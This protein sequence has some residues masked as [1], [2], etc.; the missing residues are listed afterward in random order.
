METTAE[1][2]SGAAIGFADPRCVD[3]KCRGAATPVTEPTGDGAQVDTSSKQ[4][5]RRVVPESM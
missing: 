4:L 5:G 2:L 1:D 3:P